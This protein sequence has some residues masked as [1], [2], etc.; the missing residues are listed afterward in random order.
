MA[1][2]PYSDPSFG[3]TS[4]SPAW[5]DMFRSVSIRKTSIPEPQVPEP[6][7]L[8]KDPTKRLDPDHKTFPPRDPQQRERGAIWNIKDVVC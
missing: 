6:H 8:P 3:A 7:A 4:A 1:L 5:Q 2:V